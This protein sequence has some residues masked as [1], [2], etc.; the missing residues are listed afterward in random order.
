MPTSAHAAM[1]ALSRVPLT[2]SPMPACPPGESCSN[3]SAGRFPPQAGQSLDWHGGQRMVLRYD[4]FESAL[5]GR[6]GGR[7]FLL[8][9][10]E[11]PAGGSLLHPT[12]DKAINAAPAN[13]RTAIPQPH[14]LQRAIADQLPALCGADI[15]GGAG[16]RDG[17]KRIGAGDRHLLLLGFCDHALP[18]QAWSAMAICFAATY[19]HA[20]MIESY[21]EAWPRL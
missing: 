14:H 10:S 2:H 11:Y 1:R 15:Q 9:P 6:S 5:P 12:S 18:S 7:P 13:A 21:C 17:V 16:F 3:P 20:R 8:G 19:P 4:A